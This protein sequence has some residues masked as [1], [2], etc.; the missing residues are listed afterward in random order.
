MKPLNPD[1][2]FTH[3]SVHCVHILARYMAREEVRCD[4]SGQRRAG[5]RWPASMCDQAER[6]ERE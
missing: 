3:I 5:E 4:S 1:L 6:V 2:T